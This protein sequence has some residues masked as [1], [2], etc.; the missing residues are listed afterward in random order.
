MNYQPI[1]EL[2]A[3]KIVGCEALTRFHCNFVE[4]P[5]TLFLDAKKFGLDQE[6]QRVTLSY[7]FQEFKKF[8]SDVCISLNVTPQFL[9]GDFFHGCALDRIVLELTEH[10]TIEDYLRIEQILELLRRSG[11]RLA[12]YH[13]GGGFARFWHVLQLKPDIIKLVRRLVENINFSHPRKILI[14]AVIS[15]ANQTV[16]KV[17]AEGVQTQPEVDTLSQLNVH[18]VQRYFFWGAKKNKLTNC[19]ELS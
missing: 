12:V 1:V 7:A 10:D 15:F 19:A 3:N 8:S 14:A 4:S 11:M 6:L 13:A 18:M 5:H 16:I 9:F 2:S 17:V